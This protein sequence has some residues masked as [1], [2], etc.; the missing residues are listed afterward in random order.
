MRLLQPLYPGIVLYLPFWE[1]AG[2]FAEDIAPFRNHGAI[3]GA[4]WVNGVIGK[5]LSFNGATDYVTVLKGTSLDLAIPTN[6]FTVSLWMYPTDVSYLQYVFIWGKIAN[7]ILFCRINPDGGANNLQ[8]R[9]WLSSVTYNSLVSS[10][11]I[12]NNTWYHLVIT[13]NHATGVETVYIDGV[14]CGNVTVTG[15]F[16]V[17]T[18]F[19]VGSRAGLTQFFKGLIDDVRVYNRAL[20]PSEVWEEYYR[21]ARKNY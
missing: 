11:Q 8:I 7:A 21:G 10:R 17:D 14:D 9:Q 12:E 16:V 3:T 15:S 5:A 18:A 20:T 4:T 19:Y 1:G 2:T 13:Y 6:S